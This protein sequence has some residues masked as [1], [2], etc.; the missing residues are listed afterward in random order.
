MDRG[1]EKTLFSKEKQTYIDG[2]RVHEKALNITH[3]QENAHQ[4]HEE[5]LPHAC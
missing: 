4:N 3:H 1:S 5:E 2:Q